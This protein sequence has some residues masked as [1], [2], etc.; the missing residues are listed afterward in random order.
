M[1]VEEIIESLLPSESHLFFSHGQRFFI[2]MQNSTFLLNVQWYQCVTDI[3]RLIYGRGTTNSNWD[4]VDTSKHYFP[5][6]I[7][8]IKPTWEV[9]LKVIS[10]LPIVI[11]GTLANVSL[12]HVIVRA[13]PLHTTTNLLIVN[14][15]IAD[16]L[17]CVVCP[18]LFLCSDLYQNYVM[19]PVGCRL[20]GLLVHALTLVAVF[21]LSA[22]SYDRVSAIV[23]NCSGK[24]TRRATN[25]LLYATWACGVIVAVPLAYFRQ[26]YERQWK[27]HLETYC[28][29][30]T[31]LVYPYWHIFAGLSVWAPLTIMA[32]CYSAILIKLD[33]YETQALK[34]KH[35]IVVR[36]KGRVAQVLALIVLSFILCRVPFTALIIRRAQL[37]QRPAKTGGAESIYVLWYVSRYLVLVNAAINPLL[38]G[39][40]SSCLRKELAEYPGISWLICQRKRKARICSDSQCKPQQRFL[41]LSPRSP[42]ISVND[43]AMVPNISSRITVDNSN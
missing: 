42:C 17:T 21:N 8:V 27:N 29:E 38:Y 31:V 22:V 9:V 40:S 23:L 2:D 35:P 3:E 28:T 20:D 25:V 43:K 24:L 41:H 13:K 32:V 6:E 10:V 37:L 26:Y 15:S 16:L 1:V 19:G 34:N 39:C 14:M 4:D 12:I 18:W 36:Y 7:W 33:R 11:I 5:S 30:D